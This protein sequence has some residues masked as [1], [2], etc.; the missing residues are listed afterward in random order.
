MNNLILF[1]VTLLIIG[2]CATLDREVGNGIEQDKTIQLS[3]FDGISYDLSDE[4]IV[5]EGELFEAKLIGDSNILD[6][7]ALEIRN[8]I[9]Y[10]DLVPGNYV[11][12]N[13][14]VEVTLQNLKLVENTGSGDIVIERRADDNDDLLLITDGSGNI[15]VKPQLL[16]KEISVKVDGS[17]SVSFD[18]Q[19]SASKFDIYT[20]GSGDINAYSLSTQFCDMLTDGSGEVRLTVSEELVG[21]ITGSGNTYYKGTPQ[22]RIVSDGSGR[23]INKN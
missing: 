15:E 9:L 13:M 23:L 5:K 14:K 17:G 2:S 12:I 21:T 16:L 22:I 19:T 10:I 3:S 18:G 8:G 11:N 7:I 20:D 4:L 6:N 1:I